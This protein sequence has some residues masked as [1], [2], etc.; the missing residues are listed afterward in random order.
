MGV[1]P[2]RLK[3]SWWS[4]GAL[5]PDLVDQPLCRTFGV[6][7]SGGRSVVRYWWLPTWSPSCTLPWLHASGVRRSGRS[8]SAICRIPLADV[9]LEAS[10]GDSVLA[11]YFAR[12]ILSV[13]LPEEEFSL[14]AYI[15]SFE[16]GPDGAIQF[17]LFLATAYRWYFDGMAGWDRVKEA[18]AR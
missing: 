18:L 4:L 9:P 16:L 12:S 14:I 6:L 1:P 13:P 2:T 3:H 10:S 8:R 11:V 7:E 15:V 17:A 5:L